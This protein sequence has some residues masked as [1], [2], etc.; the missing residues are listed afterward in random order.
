LLP[1]AALEAAVTVGEAVAAAVAGAASLL[2]ESN[3]LSTLGNDLTLGLWFVVFG[4]VLMFASLSLAGDA[5]S[6]ARA[7]R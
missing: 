6:R 4:G 5:L 7:L 1:G 2:M 3:A